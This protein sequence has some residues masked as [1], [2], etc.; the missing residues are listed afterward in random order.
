MDTKRT[1]FSLIIL[2][3]TF[4]LTIC[5]YPMDVQAAVEQNHEEND[6]ATQIN[7]WFPDE[8]IDW[9]LSPPDSIVLLISDN[10]A[11][12]MN[13][14]ATPI[15]ADILKLGVR[16]PLWLDSPESLAWEDAVKTL[17]PRPF[18][19]YEREKLFDWDKAYKKLGEK[20][21]MLENREVY[22]AWN[23]EFLRVMQEYG[24]LNAPGADTGSNESTVNHLF[25]PFLEVLKLRL[26]ENLGY[27]V[28]SINVFKVQT[29]QGWY[30]EFYY[31]LKWQGKS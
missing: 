17:G 14:S 3:V 23:L 11:M 12:M 8:K 30:R 4:A 31:Q 15:I 26:Y 10:A 20:P 13:P 6:P 24:I 27:T 19:N 16:P 7:K 18:K 29:L 25:P 1:I 21:K 9:L 22:D 2:T 28:D 5:I